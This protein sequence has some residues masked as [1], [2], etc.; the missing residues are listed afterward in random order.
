MVRKRVWPSA[1]YDGIRPLLE[2][3]IADEDHAPDSACLALAG[4]VDD[5]SAELPNLGWRVDRA[6]A[7]EIVGVP[8][9][10]LVN[11]FVAS[12]HG[13]LELQ[14]NDTAVLQKGVVRPGAPVA[15]LGAGTGL[16]VAHVDCG[17]RPARV[18]SSEG[19]HA[20]FA[21]RGDVEWGL[22][23]FLAERYGRASRE[24]VLSGAGL[25]DIYHY[26]AGA[27]DRDKRLVR[28]EADS[29]DSA[30]TISR[31]GLVRKNPLAARALEIFVSVYGAVAGDVALTIGARGGVF[32]TGGIVPKI[33]DAI[34]DGP[35]LESFLAKGR[36]R[37]YLAAI[38]VRVVLNDE[39]G[40]LGA[41]AAAL[42]FSG[43]NIA[44]PA[45]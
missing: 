25:V 44:A 1:Q 38:P 8:S 29:E 13:I 43:A 4:P 28:A 33:L 32:I 20:D 18:F 39:V 17:V 21:P 7:A 6:E 15:I 10:R 23:R 19:G 31:N 9:L 3:Y 27:G 41:A 16:G 14:D 36:M 42:L 30:A 26:L 40:L 37:D 35:F 45:P 5:G 12:G 34:R 24:R 2:A 22:A 11:D